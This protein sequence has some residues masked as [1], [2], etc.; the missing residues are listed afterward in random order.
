MRQVFA[1]AAV[2]A[3]QYAAP[4]S[5]GRAVKQTEHWK[6]HGST[7]RRAWSGDKKVYRGGAEARR[8][9]GKAR[10]SLSISAPP[11]LIRSFGFA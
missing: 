10:I 2:L 11:R 6:R 9:R 3:S 7:G 8:S 1:H 4:E 5:V